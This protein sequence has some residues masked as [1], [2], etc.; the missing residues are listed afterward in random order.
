MV[1]RLAY[2]K[3]EAVRNLDEPASGSMGLVGSRKD[4]AAVTG[5]GED[6]MS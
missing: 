3:F 2:F 6:R 1:I 5:G 4:D